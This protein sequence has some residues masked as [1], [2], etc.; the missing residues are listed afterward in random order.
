MPDHIL[1]SLIFQKKLNAPVTMQDCLAAL[2][3]VKI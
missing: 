3:K 1:K 2:E